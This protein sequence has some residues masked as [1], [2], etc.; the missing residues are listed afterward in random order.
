MKHEVRHEDTLFGR[1]T[2]FSD[3]QLLHPEVPV[4]PARVLGTAED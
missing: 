1:R 3:I 4:P 2:F